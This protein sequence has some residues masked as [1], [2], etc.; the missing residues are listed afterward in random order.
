MRPMKGINKIN[1]GPSRF[2]PP[3]DRCVRCVFEKLMGESN[4]KMR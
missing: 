2:S 3:K 1:N 4:R